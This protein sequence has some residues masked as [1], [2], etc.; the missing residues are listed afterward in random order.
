MHRGLVIQPTY[1]I[2]GGVPI[3]QLYGR[4][5][6]GEA[7]QVEDD[8]FRPYFFVPSVAADAVR[9]HRDVELEDTLL[10]D[11]HGTPV[12]RVT[13]PVPAAVVPLR[14]RLTAQGIPC[15]EA[16]IR[17]PYRFLIDQGIRAGIEIEGE[18]EAAGAGLLYF[19]NPV[20]RPATA[21]PA[22]STLSI[23]LETTPDASKILSVAL[24]GAGADDVELVSERPVAGAHCPCRR[25]IRS[26]P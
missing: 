24:V 6:S 23:D 15:L 16:D 13:V 11:L 21:R 14:E 7:F 18:A 1:R 3:V 8:R 5:E 9:D 12:T 19:H 20:L 4:L 10:R 22:L 26:K 25:R 2:R 17:F